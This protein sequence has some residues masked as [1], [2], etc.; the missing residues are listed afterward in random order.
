L[1]SIKVMARASTARSPARMPAAS[2]ATSGLV[3]V[4]S[5]RCAMAFK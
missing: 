5:G 2:F 1:D 3:R 4:D